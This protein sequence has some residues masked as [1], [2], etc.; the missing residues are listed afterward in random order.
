MSTEGINEDGVITFTP[1]R[2]IEEPVVFLGFTDSEVVK[3]GLISG[4]I[5]IPFAVLIL[6]PFGYAL[7]GVGLGMGLAVLMMFLL[8]KKLAVLKRKYPDG[9]HEVYIKQ[10]LQAKTP[11]NFQYIDYEGTWSIRRFKPINR[12]EKEEQVDF[13]SEDFGYSD[14][15][16]EFMPNIEETDFQPTLSTEQSHATKEND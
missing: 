10:K 2:L 6:L 12:I 7:L 8:G 16:S 15:L 1:D 13:D 14:D 4:A 11:M 9:L 5:S 3:G